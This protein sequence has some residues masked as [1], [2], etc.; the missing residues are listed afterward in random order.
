M[1][2]EKNGKI[3]NTDQK[4]DDKKFGKGYEEIQWKSKKQKSS[5]KSQN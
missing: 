2:L 3:K 1:S 5:E 4:V